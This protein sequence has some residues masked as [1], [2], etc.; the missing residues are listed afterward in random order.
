M[1]F[2]REI[3]I[4]FLPRHFEILNFD[5]LN[6]SHVQNVGQILGR[7]DEFLLLVKFEMYLAINMV[8][9][10]LYSLVCFVIEDC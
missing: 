1:S 7:A 10:L 3:C 2:R 4:R 8:L 5:I 6:V 9:L